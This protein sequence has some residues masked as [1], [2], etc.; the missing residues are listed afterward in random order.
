MYL[1]LIHYVQ[2]KLNKKKTTENKRYSCKKNK[3]LIKKSRIITP[4]PR[5]IS[6]RVNQY[7][8]RAVSSV[9]TL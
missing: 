9:S 4:M 7:S 1:I 2:H 8:L 5:I 6:N 3:N